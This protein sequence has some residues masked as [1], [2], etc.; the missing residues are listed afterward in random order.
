MPRAW[1][2]HDAPDILVLLLLTASLVGNVYLG[3]RVIGDNSVRHA[4]GNL[5][6]GATIQSLEARDSTGDVR[7]IRFGDGSKATVLLVFSAQCTWCKRTWPQ[8]VRLAGALDDRFDF[9]ALCLDSHVS[10]FEGPFP[11][12]TS[13]SPS[14]V[15]AL[16]VRSV[17]QTVV[18]GPGGQVQKV[19][20]GAYLG[21]IAADMGRYFSVAI[22][23]IE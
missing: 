11:I 10:G 20:N 6:V 7:T 8:F 2:S 5:P 12:L 21:Q 16:G 9:V 1:L 19:W 17:P 14:T 23:P 3:M 22:E 4:E 13:P 18:V 15:A